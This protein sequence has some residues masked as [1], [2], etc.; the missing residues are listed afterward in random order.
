[1][2]LHDK[3]QLKMNLYILEAA[4]V[5]QH[6]FNCASCRVQRNVKF[7]P[8]NHHQTV[9]QRLENKA[10]KNEAYLLHPCVY[11][12]GVSGARGQLLK[13]EPFAKL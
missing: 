8:R 2:R 1:M 9:Y 6:S 11:T 5:T 7:R 10:K 4:Q 3:L 13:F 12:R